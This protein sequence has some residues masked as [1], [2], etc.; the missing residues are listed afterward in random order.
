METHNPTA[1]IP[2][3]ET[4]SVDYPLPP[5]RIAQYPLPVRDESKLLYADARTGSIR[6]HVFYELPKLLPTGAFLVRNTTRVLPARLIATK[7]TGGKVEILLISPGDGRTIEQALASQRSR[8]ECLLGGRRIRRGTVLSALHNGKGIIAEVLGSNGMLSDLT[9]ECI[10]NTTTLA[11]QLQYLGQLPLPPYI[12]RTPTAE[13]L[14]RYQTVYAQR[15]GSVAAPTAGLH[16][17]ERVL[18]A[19]H[20]Q[21]TPIVDVVLHVGIGTFQP[22]RA[23]VASSHAMHAER[24]YVE[25][26]SIEQLHALVR[27]GDRMC[28]C[29]GTTSV[30]TVETLYWFGVKLINGIT[31]TQLLLTQEEPYAPPLSNSAVAPADA[32]EAVLD[33]LVQRNMDALEGETQLYIVPGYRYRIPQAMITNFHQPRSTLL[34]LVAAFIGPWW[35][36]IYAEALA[37]GYRFLSYGDASLLIANPESEDGTTRR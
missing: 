24:I 15:S 27:N 4:S 20:S 30:R 2:P 14:K 3:I 6:H 26:S 18:A 25:R 35:R 13:D 9:I 11:E 33:W 16:F 29:V 19:L 32:L 31:C 17:T 28:V 36:T 8:W 34:L 12:H 7:P 21:G 23:E 10:P 1:H 5:D 22:L 37:N